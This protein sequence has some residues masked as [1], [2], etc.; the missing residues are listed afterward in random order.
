MRGPARAWRS[1]SPPDSARLGGLFGRCR[2]AGARR[3]R[4]LSADDSLPC[5]PTTTTSRSPKFQ[6]P[7][8]PR[9]WAWAPPPS[10]GA[11]CCRGSARSRRAARTGSSPTSRPAA[12][13]TVAAEIVVVVEA[14]DTPRKAHHDATRRRCLR[15]RLRRASAR[16]P[17]CVQRHEKAAEAQRR[18]RQWMESGEDL[19]AAGRCPRREARPRRG[20]GDL[21]AADRRRRKGE[22][23]AG[24][25]AAMAHRSTIDVDHRAVERLK[26]KP[27]S[28]SPPR[29]IVASTRSRRCVDIKTKA[30]TVG[31]NVTPPRILGVHRPLQPGDC[32]LVVRRACG[33]HHDPRN[34]LPKSRTCRRGMGRRRGTI[35]RQIR[36]CH[37]PERADQ[38]A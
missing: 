17:T 22:P 37:G 3:L 12:N 28:G 31:A 8:S 36:P 5:S 34:A 24:L 9:R 10:S 21:D 35:P 33:Q 4:V 6:R 23:R 13:S 32:V 29:W 30:L 38:A 15:D 25:I 16:S 14:L 11:S 2:Q 7:R 1:A 18:K 27:V 19:K 20:C 26:G